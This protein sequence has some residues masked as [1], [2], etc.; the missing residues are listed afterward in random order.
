MS[1]LYATAIPSAGHFLWECFKSDA[2]VAQK[3]ISHDIWGVEFKPKWLFLNALKWHL[4]KTNHSCPLKSTLSRPCKIHHTCWNIPVPNK[5]RI[6]SEKLKTYARNVVN[7]APSISNNCPHSLL[8]NH[9]HLPGDH[10]IVN[11]MAL[12][13]YHRSLNPLSVCTFEL[14]LSVPTSTQM[15]YSRNSRKISCP[16]SAFI[17]LG[18]RFF[19]PMLESSSALTL[20]FLCTSVGLWL[21]CQ[22]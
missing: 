4:L 5:A 13:I 14:C 21:R 10:D 7:L 16:G 12:Y 8:A 11:F 19:A 20:Y 6:L 3:L 9:V 15:L 2:E 1:R 18:F 22:Y 17:S